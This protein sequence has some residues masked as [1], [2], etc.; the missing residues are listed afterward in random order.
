MEL[1][2]LSFFDFNLCFFL[3]FIKKKNNDG[4]ASVALGRLFATA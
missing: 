1:F 4:K 2:P 3:G